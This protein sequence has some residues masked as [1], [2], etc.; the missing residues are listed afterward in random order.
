MS[1]RDPD[2]QELD[3]L[4]HSKVRL[5]AIAVLASA[6]DAEFTYLRDR[7][8]TTD[9]N[10]STHMRRLE[11]AGYVEV[12]KSF[13]ERKPLTRYRLTPRG[14]RAFKEYVDRLER[15]LGL[16]ASSGP[17]KPDTRNEGEDT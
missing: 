5:G 2:V 1:G 8:N 10:L 12:R 13:V 15:L 4:I 16:G 3:D 17:G 6:D 7:L 11:E 9:G 14:R